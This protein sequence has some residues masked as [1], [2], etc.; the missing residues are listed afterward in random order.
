[1]APRA[2]NSF[3]QAEK[4]LP[5]SFSFVNAL[6]MLYQFT[7]TCILDLSSFS[8]CGICQ[9][10]NNPGYHGL[11]SP[12]IPQETHVKALALEWLQPSFLP[13]V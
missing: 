10:S 8:I 1:M 6:S 11:S 12:W 13:L 5:A 4:H 2:T 9:V 7:M 3:P